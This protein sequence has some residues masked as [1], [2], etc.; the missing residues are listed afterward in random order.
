MKIAVA[1]D[2]RGFILKEFLKSELIKRNFLLSDLGTDSKH[3][4]DYPDFAKKAALSLINNDCQKAIVICGSGVGVNIALN[5]F[6]GIRAGICHD[7]YSAHQG[8]EH[9]DM[10]ALVLGADIVG[11][12]LALEISFVFIKSKFSN[13]ERHIKRLEKIKLIEDNNL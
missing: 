1:S 10:N 4:V 8:V 5:K 12:M 2:H 13:E 11:E 3:P 6:S 7:T 9:D